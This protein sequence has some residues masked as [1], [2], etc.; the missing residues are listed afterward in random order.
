M[1]RR[2]EIL[3]GDKKIYSRLSDR[4]KRRVVRI[5]VVFAVIVYVAWAVTAQ[6]EEMKVKQAI[7]DI[8]RIEH[9]ARLFKVDEGRCPDDVEELISPEWNN[10]YT[11][12]VTDPWG[13]P[14]RLL[15]PAQSDPNGVRVV[16]GGPNGA[17]GMD[18]DISSL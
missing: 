18:D 3:L 11:A 12:P 15:C 14:Y 2:R 9:V 16:S 10:R 6:S 13:S 1:R 4:F 5:L 17:K 7:V 8:S